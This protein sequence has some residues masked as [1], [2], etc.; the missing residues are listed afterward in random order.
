[1]EQRCFMAAEDNKTL[2]YRSEFAP[3]VLDLCARQKM[4]QWG[5]ADT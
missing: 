5:F 1:M 3:R 2:Y 4:A